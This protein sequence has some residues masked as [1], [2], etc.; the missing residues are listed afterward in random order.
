MSDIRFNG[1]LHRSGTGGVW[2]DSSGNV[3]IGSSVP[4]NAAVSANTKVLN[5]GVITATTYYGSGANLTGIT[6]TTI[7]NNADN[8]L[9][10][11]SG[12]ANTLEGEVNLTWNGTNQLKETGSGDTHILI[13]STDAGGASIYF[14]GD[15]DG[16]GAGSD[17]SWIKHNTSGDM[18]YVVDNPAA[19]GVH[20][21]KTAGTT[22]RLRIDNDGKCIIPD[23]GRFS[24][25]AGEDLYLY[26]DGTQGIIR[27]PNSNLHLQSDAEVIIGDI[28]G[29]EIFGKFADDGVVSLYS[30]NTKVF[31]TTSTGIDV[32]GA[33]GGDCNIH[34]SADEG[35]DD[36]DRWR[37]NVAA[38]GGFSIDSATSGSWEEKMNIA[39]ADNGPIVCC[40]VDSGV[41]NGGI[42]LGNAN[43][44]GK[45][46]ATGNTTASLFM[47]FNPGNGNV[48]S[49]KTNA[50]ATS[51]NTS[52][53][54]RLKENEVPLENA[55]TKLKALKPYTFNF[56]TY[57]SDKVDGFYAHEAAEVVPTAVTGTK[58]EMAP[59]YYKSGDTIPEGKKV[60]DWTGQYSSTE[61]NPQGVDY[62]KFT[63]L[64]TKALQE[65]VARVEA[66]E[67]A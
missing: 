44:G 52:S 40:A 56:K 46:Y 11:G 9:I 50:A 53:D 29:N 64:L 1:W 43:I 5:V 4:S 48:G 37:L 6:G 27:A 14:D 28:G 18:E 59:T 26:S 19:A 20:I 25:G 16:D 60:G 22:E 15:S 32:W 3:G 57:P 51:F 17:Y 24:A 55:I 30:D 45:W 63:P 35:D 49:I 67:S 31:A 33:E 23:N 38:G 61:I 13:G 47:F 62:G 7:N 2:Q 54:Y 41:T 10:T 12:T 34:L 66:L 65:L 39:M 8:R 58:D 42:S 21:F 36:D